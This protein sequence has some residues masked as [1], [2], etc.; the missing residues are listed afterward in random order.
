MEGRYKCLLSNDVVVT[1]EGGGKIY[2]AFIAPL[3]KTATKTEQINQKNWI[4]LEIDS[5]IYLCGVYDK[6]STQIYQRSCK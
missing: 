5:H 2:T 6:G 3:G 4:Y 1:S